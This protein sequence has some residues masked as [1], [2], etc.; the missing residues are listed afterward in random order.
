MHTTHW[1]VVYLQCLWW[2]TDWQMDQGSGCRGSLT[3][4]SVSLRKV[5]LENRPFPYYSWITVIPLLD[6][7][8]VH[9]HQL[10]PLGR[11]GLVVAMSVCCCCPLPMQFFCVVGLVQRVPRPWT[12]AIPISISNRALKTRMCSGVWSQSQSRVKPGKQGCVPEFNL[13]RDLE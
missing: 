10:G 3:Q 12:G 11:V 13:D 5:W 6:A 9:F 4:H 7:P 2:L 1:Q 8:Q